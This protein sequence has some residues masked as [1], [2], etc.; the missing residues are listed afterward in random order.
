MIKE[1]EMPDRIC[2]D[3]S[4][5]FY[6]KFGRPAKRCVECRG[7]HGDPA[8][9]RASSPEN[10][11]TAVGENCHRC[12]K[13]MLAGQPLDL[14]HRDDGDGWAWSHSRCNRAAGAAKINRARAAAWRRQQ[15]LPDSPQRATGAP[16]AAQA[17]HQDGGQ[18][19]IGTF[20]LV[21]EE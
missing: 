14:D 12:G 16:S 15:G 5:S 21:D 11:A 13:P 18:P 2:Q 9:R 1:S 8:F 19:I 20:H 6:Q 17:R 10:R 7:K 4:A 3:C